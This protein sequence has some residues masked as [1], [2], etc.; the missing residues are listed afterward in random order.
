MSDNPFAAL[1]VATELLSTLEDLGYESPSPVQEQS[2]PILLEGG[3]LLA[4]A[5]TGTGKTAAFALP[6]LSRLD[7]AKNYPQALVLAPTRELAIQVAEA[8]KTY[9]RKTTGFRVLP[10][11]GGQDYSI[12]LKALKRGVHVVVG[13]PGRVM[14]H[15]RR[16]TLSI[17]NLT[18]IVLD[19]ADEMLKMG[20][21][22]D[23]EWILE[24]IDVE[25][26]TALFSAT[27][28]PA[29]CKVAAKYLK[30]AR[31]V[32]IKPKEKTAPTIEQSYMMVSNH[33][34]LE[35]LT[36][37][38]EVEDF[39]GVL[40]FTRT[41]TAS[42]ELA[43]KLEAR[44]HDA[45]AL[46][47]DMTQAMREKVV[48]RMKRGTLSIIVAT[49]VAARGLDIERIGHVINYDIPYDS[50]SY[51]HRIGRTGRAG[52]KGKSLLF[53]TPREQRMLSEIQRG[54]S[55]PI[56]PVDPPSA[57]QISEKR[58]E[59]FSATV[60]GALANK[61]LD[62]YRELAS[63]M[64]DDGDCSILDIAAALM[65]LAQKDKPLRVSG[66]DL[67]CVAKPQPYGNRDRGGPPRRGG[68]SRKRFGG[69]GSSDSRKP[70]GNRSG[71]GKP[72]G[73][74][75]QPG[76]SRSSAPAGG[77]PDSAPRKRRK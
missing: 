11:Y 15:L 45:A 13:T 25:H 27:M 9:A 20:F 4:Q 38:L 65:F 50:E 75:G 30:D 57:K 63:S 19:E 77:K 12:Q 39:D 24:Q 51:V 69:G 29:I 60:Q 62:T 37:F 14:D 54:L 44:G 58:A 66:D 32:S 16:K 76:G 52:R 40:I 46:N 48:S 73:S 53:V 64:A 42:V 70:G 36:R 72:S 1:G 28:P 26:Q 55:Q 59:S 8:F 17:E 21:I 41:K 67:R 43:E 33:H 22:D 23:V 68:P 35:A 71:G 5:Q 31:K 34:K 56:K 74:G 61:H 2:I 18:T 6:I 47:G 7:A 3:D 49:E 10:I